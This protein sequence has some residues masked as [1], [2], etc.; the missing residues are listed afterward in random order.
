MAICLSP[1][2]RRENLLGSLSHEPRG[3]L[4]QSLATNYRALTLLS[5][6]LSALERLITGLVTRQKSSKMCPFCPVIFGYKLRNSLRGLDI[7]L[8]ASI[9][10][11]IG[12]KSPFSMVDSLYLL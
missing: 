10:P 4:S 8:S 5:Q 6:E 3:N 9:R 12:Y 11:D 2:Y 7:A 1:L